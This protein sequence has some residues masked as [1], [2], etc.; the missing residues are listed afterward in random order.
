MR[1]N[2][3]TTRLLAACVAAALAAALVTFLV[4][5]HRSDH[6]SA[7]A[8]S[9]AATHN[10]QLAAAADRLPN[11]TATEWTT[12]A[13]YVAVVTVSA[14]HELPPTDTELSQGQGLI[15]R[16]ITVDGG[17]VLWSKPAARDLPNTLEQI[18]FGWKF[19]NGDVQDREKVGV[20]GASR[21]E[22]GHTYIMALQWTDARCS[23]GDKVPAGW[24]GLGSAST[25][26]YDNQ[27]VGQGEMEGAVRTVKQART[28]LAIEPADDSVYAL[29][30]GKSAD[31]VRNLLNTAPPA[32][33][34]FSANS[35]EY[36]C[37]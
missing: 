2:I 37:D 34:K 1:A 9:A 26:P 24:R 27:I 20:N 10:I 16:S 31:A 33:Q 25:L 23:P 14:Q 3:G 32:A 18:A 17:N 30:L 15:L 12:Y 8:K 7:V 29:T 4:T 21:M 36:T 11:E 5:T 28:A 13:D 35:T 6:S 22:V 19:G